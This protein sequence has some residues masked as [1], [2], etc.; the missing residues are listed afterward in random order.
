[1]THGE[2]VPNIDEFFRLLDRLTKKLKSM[3]ANKKTKSPHVPSD[4]WSDK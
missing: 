2:R 1:M 3:S 4:L